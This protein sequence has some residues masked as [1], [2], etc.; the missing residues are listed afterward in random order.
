[1]PL[2]P[3]Q[4]KFLALSAFRAVRYRVASRLSEE[5]LEANTTILGP[6]L[7][8]GAKRLSMRNGQTISHYK[9]IEQIG[10]GSWESSAR[11]KTLLLHRFVAPQIPLPGRTQG[12]D[13]ETKPP[14][15]GP[16]RLCPRSPEYL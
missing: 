11:Q 6:R 15:G 10:S 12:P 2:T 16:S 9:V 4:S 8:P 1:M 5:L 3:E 14:P 13:S 7:A